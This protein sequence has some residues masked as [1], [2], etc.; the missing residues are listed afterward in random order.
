MPVIGYIGPGDA[1]IMEVMNQD[2]APLAYWVSTYPLGDVP[3]YSTLG[4]D[5]SGFAVDFVRFRQDN[6]TWGTGYIDYES[7]DNNLWRLEEKSDLGSL[8]IGGNS[9]RIAGV[10]RAAKVVNEL[11]TT[12]FASLT[13]SKVAFATEAFRHDTLYNYVQIAYYYDDTNS[14]WKSISGH[15]MYIDTQILASGDGKSV[16]N[17]KHN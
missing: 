2:T 14:T 15:D 17:I 7:N 9:C 4:G 6:G 8:T 16:F 10:R 12:V 1:F 3:V 13:T 11:G 5:P